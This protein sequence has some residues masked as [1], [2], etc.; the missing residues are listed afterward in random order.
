MAKAVIGYTEEMTAMKD[1]LFLLNPSSL[2]LEKII[3]SFREIM[4]E[5]ET[6]LDGDAVELLIGCLKNIIDLHEGNITEKEYLKNE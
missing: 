1:V 5:K 3:L 2:T 4:G 6:P